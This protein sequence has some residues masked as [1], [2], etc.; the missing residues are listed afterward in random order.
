MVKLY[1]LRQDYQQQAM[2]IL[3]KCV[4]NMDVSEAN[5]LLQTV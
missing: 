5:K 2:L 1:K 3:Q 4:A